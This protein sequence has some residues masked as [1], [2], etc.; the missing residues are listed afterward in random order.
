VRFAPTV[1]SQTLYSGFL[2]DEIMLARRVYLTIG[3]K[4]E[5]NGYTGFEFEPSARVA[6]ESQVHTIALGRAI[7]GSAH[8][9]TLRPGLVRAAAA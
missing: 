1:L 4:L 9:V 7:A 2:Q 5:H 3:S 8:T 6:M